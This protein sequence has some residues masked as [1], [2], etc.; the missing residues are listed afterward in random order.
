MGGAALAMTGLSAPPGERAQG[1]LS[2]WKEAAS[3]LPLMDAMGAPLAALPPLWVSFGD[4]PV[5][6]A[7]ILTRSDIHP[8]EYDLREGYTPLARLGCEKAITMV[9]A[10]H[11]RRNGPETEVVVMGPEPE[12]LMDIQNNVKAKTDITALANPQGW[13]TRRKIEAAWAIAEEWR[14]EMAIALKAYLKEADLLGLPKTCLGCACRDSYD[15]VFIKA[16]IDQGVDGVCKEFGVPPEGVRKALKTHKEVL[17]GRLE[18]ACSAWAAAYVLHCA[19]KLVSAAEMAALQA[20][21][22]VGIAEAGNF[23]A[24]EDAA[25]NVEGRQRE[26]VARKIIALVGE[27]AEDEVRA[28]FHAPRLVIVQAPRMAQPLPAAPAG[29]TDVPVKAE[30]KPAEKEPRRTL[31][32]RVMDLARELNGIPPG[33]IA[34]CFREGCSDPDAIMEKYTSPPEAAAPQTGRHRLHQAEAGPESLQPGRAAPFGAAAMR[35]I[36]REGLEAAHVA[37]AVSRVF[38]YPH[39]PRPLAE[40]AARAELKRR[41]NGIRAPDKIADGVLRFIRTAG[42][43]KACGRSKSGDMIAIEAGTENQVGRDILAGV[44]A[45]AGR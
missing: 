4:H 20:L 31:K 11:S 9:G 30:E 37:L 21:E 45:Q 40:D 42:L 28:E 6:P 27:D 23:L 22:A 33:F 5:R 17:Y 7:I 29:S 16:L 36:A 12:A 26:R 14:G 15:A 38:G 19:A 44:R 39:K 2:R 18:L 1:K 10:L 3:A 43:I 34:R 35:A 25:G 32:E 8:L 24:M 41:L 13:E